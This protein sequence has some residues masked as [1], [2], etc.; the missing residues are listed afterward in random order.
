MLA[1]QRG[2]SVRFDD[3][4]SAILVVDDDDSVGELVKVYLERAGYAVIGATDGLEGLALF[5]QNRTAIGLVLTD[6]EMPKMTGLDLADRIQQ[7]DSKVPVLF[8]SGSP[9]H[10]DR[11]YGCVQKPFIHS[12]LIGRVRA[13]LSRPNAEVPC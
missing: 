3:H 5:R 10:A 4:S 8:M 6:V 7:L 11:G 1:R 13:A 12:E 9:V 2:P